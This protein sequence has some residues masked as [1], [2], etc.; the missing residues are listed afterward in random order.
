MESN[1][2]LQ[3]IVSLLEEMRGGY[4]F[5]ITEITQ[6]ENELNIYGDDAVELILEYA[7]LF[8]VDVSKFMLSDYFADE[9]LDLF[10]IFRKK[11]KKILTIGDLIK[12]I[13]AGKLNEEVLSKE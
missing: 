9:G 11:K 10:S 13:K 4:D 5:P 3:K 1:N 6:I 7:K 2:T 12:G 8:D